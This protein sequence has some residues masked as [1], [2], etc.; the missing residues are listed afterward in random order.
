M[1][2]LFCLIFSFSLLGI[3]AAQDTLY[4]CNFDSTADATGWQLLNGDEYN[5]W[6]IG[7]AN[8]MGSD[9]L[10]ITVNGSE[11]R[12]SPYYSSVTY[13]C[14]RLWLPSGVCRVSY[15]WMCNGVTDHAYMR[16]LLAPKTFQWSAG[17]LP[18][19]M[20]GIPGASV[21]PGCTALDGSSQLGGTMSWRRGSSE[22][23][24]Q[25]ADTFVLVFMWYNDAYSYGSS[26]AAAV[27]NLLVDRPLCPQPT[28][29][30]VERLEPTSF[31]MAWSD[32]SA[33]GATQWL[34]E[35]DSLAQTFGQGRV[36][37]VYDTTVTFTGLTADADY[38][39]YVRA[40]CGADTGDA[41]PLQIHTPCMLLT[42]VPY[43]QDFETVTDPVPPCWRRIMTGGVVR[44]EGVVGSLPP[45][46]LYWQPMAYTQRYMV[47][48]GIDQAALPMTTLQLSFQCKESA[49][50]VGRDVEVGVMSN[51]MDVETFEP[52]GTVRVQ[53]TEWEDYVVE[54]F[55]YTG[56]GG[57]IAL[58][59]MGEG[60]YWAGGGDYLMFD[61]V[62]IEQAAYCQQVRRLEVGRVGV[63]GALLSWQQQLGV[64]NGID[65]YEIR[66]ARQDTVGTSP[67]APDALQF[68]SMETYCVLSG[69]E[70][71]TPYRAW[72][73]AHC[74]NDSLGGWDSLDFSTLSMP[75]MAGDSAHA[76]TVQCGTGTSTSTGVPISYMYVHSFCQ[77]IYPAATLRADGMEAGMITGMDYFFTNNPHDMTAAIYV[78]TT[79]DTCFASLEDRVE[80][81]DQQLVYGP[82]L[83]AAGN[84]GTVHFDFDTP[85]SW[86][87]GDNLVVTTIFNNASN[88]VQSSMFYGYSTATGVNSTIHSYLID[89]PFTPTNITSGVA[90]MSQRRPSV[91]F[92]TQPCAEVAVCVPPTVVVE[93][94]TDRSASV[95]WIGGTFDTDWDLLYRPLYGTTSDADDTLWRTVDTHIVTS[96]YMLTSLEPL[97][98]YEVRVVAHC[99]GG[100]VDGQTLFATRCGAIEALPWVEDFESF[101]A[102]SAANGRWEPCWYRYPGASGVNVSTNY[103]Y[104]GSKSLMM[105]VS[106]SGDYTYMVTPEMDYDMNRLQV[107]FRAHDWGAVTSRQY[108]LKVGVMSDPA[109]IATFVE[110]A[111]VGPTASGV[112]EE[113]EVL[114]D[115]YT[116]EGRYVALLL[117]GDVTRV[118]I[119]DLTVGQI[120]LCRR[121][122]NVTVD[123]VTRSTAVVQWDG[124]LVRDYE[125]E[126]GPSG[127][128][129]GTGSV[130]TSVFDS[131]TLVGL[132]H[133][134]QYDVYV[135]GICGEDTSLRSLAV[136]FVTL[137]GE[138]DTLPYIQN[139]SHQGVGMSAQPYCWYCGGMYIYPPYIV[140][141]TSGGNTLRQRSLYM[142]SGN[143]MSYAILPAID[144]L[145]IPIN[146]LQ[147]VFKA[148][149][150]NIYTIRQSHDLIVGICSVENEIAS[151]TPLDTVSISPVPGAYEVL[152]DS[153]AGLGAHI[154]FLSAPTAGAISNG[155]Y[156]DSV[157]IMPVPNC[158][159]PYGLEAACPSHT[160]ASL[161]WRARGGAV[162]WQV[163][164]MPHGVSLDS[165]TLVDVGTTSLTLS[166]LTPA[167][168]YD[169]HV[170]SICYGGDTSEWSYSVGTFVTQQAP[171]VVPYTYNF[172]SLEEWNRWQT[173]SNTTVGW[174][175][176]AAEGRTS[177]YISADS[178]ATR[179]ANVI[180]VINAVA[181]R[182]IDFGNL[183]TGFII[184]FAA[185]VGV[186]PNYGG[187]FLDG[188]AVFLADPTV[189]PYPP[190]DYIDQTPWGT[191]DD[192]T[193]LADI[194]GSPLWT[195]YSIVIDSLVG[196]HRLVFCCYS[197]R[198]PSSLTYVG[199][200]AAVDNVSIQYAPCQRPY[201]IRAT[202]VTAAS[203]TIGWHGSATADYRVRLCNALGNE[204]SVDTVHTNHIHYTYLLPSTPYRVEVSRLCDYFESRQEVSFKFYTLSCD[205]TVTDTIGSPVGT[206]S[207]YDVPVH[208]CYPYSYTQQIVLPSELQGRGEITSI[209]FLYDSPY[210]LYNKTNCTIYLGTTTQRSLPVDP[211]ILVPVYIGHLDFAQG[212]NR[213]LLG[214]PYPYNA[215]GNL[216]I[217]IDDNSRRGHNSS[218]YFATT[219]TVSPMAITYFG[220]NNVVCSSLD[221]LDLY[222]GG[223]SVLSYRS[224]MT[225]DICPPNECP[226]PQIQE[227][228]VH[229]ND[230]VLNWRRN[231][232]MGSVDSS[233]SAPV[234]YL[235]GYRRADSDIW[236]EDNV[237]TTDT[238]FTVE[239]FVYGESYVYHVRQYCDSVSLSNWVMG[240]FNS[241]DIPCLSP[242][243][244]HVVGVTNTQV[245]FEWIPEDNNVS[246]Q[247]HLWGS[248]ID[249][250]VTA[251]LANCTIDGLF[252]AARYY[253]SVQ[254]QCEYLD[255][256]SPWGDT[257]TF[258][259]ILCPDVTGVTAL[260]VGGNT[261]LLDWD[262][263]PDVLSWEVEWGLVGFDHGSGGMAATDRHPYLI[264]GLTGE[265]TYEISVR[266]VCGDDYYSEGWSPRITITTGYSDIGS[267]ADDSRVQLQP[268]PTSGD[269]SLSLPDTE[270]AVHVE[271]V[272]MAGRTRQTYTLVPHTSNALLNTSKLPQGAYYVRLTGSRI[273]A[274]KKL[275][276]NR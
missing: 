167:T 220:Y 256:P 111:T 174:Y 25:E 245:S 108:H 3:V 228:R 258:N 54:L 115:T 23:Y 95:E 33:T 216:V 129:P 165:G 74:Y 16:V 255:E 102:S 198:G 141:D 146:T 53:S 52:V 114:L 15:D 264:T 113:K 158:P 48:P 49:A 240:S 248:G 241:A 87:G 257:I 80:L 103:A 267:M 152:L 225:F 10:F 11:N 262:D 36:V 59:D 186:R 9:A 70:P 189:A 218:Y 180:R 65:G 140:D 270:D 253:A 269:V 169:F 177:M 78:G 188:M 176:G 233:E 217:A 79:D 138:I 93:Q 39:V 106:W 211:E 157:A 77:S 81:Q 60:Y 82:A 221:S 98:D 88:A 67:T 5:Y 271:V 166:G 117:D 209:N 131:V 161:S 229:A 144:T 237:P 143:H 268:N 243:G 250:I 126:Y 4:Q 191:F 101:E 207:L 42:A 8:T 179:S 242:L 34:V 57:Y 120:Q 116:G 224:L 223:R 153:A 86:D 69:L 45:R 29:L 18:Y 47:L 17:V 109:D 118:Y 195:D 201:S 273:S 50:G 203:A 135:R 160:T 148:H 199:H 182:D 46:V 137:C 145:R 85:L 43:V 175:R 231:V 234:R 12:Y 265:T 193:L 26:Q 7:R 92:H 139:F 38:R 41:Y 163:V 155:V 212:W 71:S 133:S 196:V 96:H 159:T 128:E 147:V 107:N 200:H 156:L 230:V 236:I 119:D 124:N 89:E 24:V 132:R 55:N 226:S 22:C 73:R 97:T 14:R 274:V 1:K 30:H 91:E 154:A 202:E 222:E 219:P 63:T 252:P 276:V 261:V 13:A 247:L 21:P 260:E 213:V 37:S 192:L 232:P 44:A 66:V 164:Y 123:R 32:R 104:S 185:S 206:V 68:S 162:G 134:C 197:E 168:R 238:F 127:F 20:Y 94:V 76:D 187:D 40:V 210:P 125:V 28:A 149:D 272:D 136:T 254:V 181:Y 99:G 112:W 244:L 227:P 214:T 130:V 173:L 171:A 151:F 204:L 251:Y 205:E 184:T 100:S 2:K 62:S 56:D 75:C 51:P 183:D 172:D 122:R 275:I 170:R 110:V 190:S 58:R 194:S 61:N 121:P 6:T 27:D 150:D 249:T 64:L 178:G 142:P 235:V 83:Y 215:D 208:T 31:T 19:S 90:A 72:V 105:T 84:Q 35:I 263:S 266:S 259:T 246:Y 239:H